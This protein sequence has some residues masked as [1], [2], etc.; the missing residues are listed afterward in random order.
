[1][2]ARLWRMRLSGNGSMLCQA[3]RISACKEE[4]HAR[5]QQQQEAMAQGA[6]QRMGL[7]T[8]RHA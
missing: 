5:V 3:A 7:P 8:W 6:W 1:M 2:Q 4:C